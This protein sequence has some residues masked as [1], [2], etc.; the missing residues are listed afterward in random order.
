M[1]AANADCTVLVASCDRYADVIGPFGRLFA[2]FWPDCPFEVVLVT[3]SD[4]GPV[5]GVSRV[6]ACGTGGTWASRL[7]QALDT[8]TT[9]YVLMLCDDYYLEAPVDTARL[10]ARLDQAR[11]LNAAN[12]R[13]IPNPRDFRPWAAEGLPL[14][15]YPKNTAYCISTLAG[16]WARDFLRRLAAQADSIWE[17]ERHGSFSC[18]DERRP[19]LVTPTR[20]F[21]F[22]DAVHKGYWEPF[23][24]AVCA[25]NGITLDFAARGR[26]PLKV[27]L[28]ETF[29]AWVFALFPATWIVRV[30]N[31]LDIG[32]KESKDKRR[33]GTGERTAR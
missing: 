24:C 10:L 32:A 21:P 17:F 1:A 25:R 19:L 22:V 3:E 7:V 13:L 14:G 2:R 20:E 12:L 8:V 5:A 16:F 15:E 31:L 6:L 27:R 11:R 9:P 4:P 23:G 18:A 28:S 26:P 29:K 33:D 30:Q